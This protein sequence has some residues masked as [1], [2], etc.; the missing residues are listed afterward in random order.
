[1]G[2]AVLV[3]IIW[4]AF[5]W[6][7]VQWLKMRQFFEPI[8]KPGRVPMETGPSPAGIMLGCLWR[9]FVTIVVLAMVFVVL[10]WALGGL[11]G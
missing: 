9:I 11:Y 1:M 3:W 10:I 8:R 2:V 4:G 6:L 5:S 7:Y